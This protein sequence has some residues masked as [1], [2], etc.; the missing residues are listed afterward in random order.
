MSE[1]QC[2]NKGCMKKYIESENHEEACTFHPG[3]PQFHDAYKIWNCCNKKSTDFSTWF[4]FPGCARGRHDNTKKTDDNM[5]RIAPPQEIRPEKPDDVIVWN[6]LNKPEEN[7]DSN[8]PMTTLLLKTTAGAEAALARLAE[9]KQADSENIDLSALSIG[10]PCR[11][12]CCTKTYDGP[13][14]KKSNCVYHPGVAIFHEGMKFWSCCNKKTSNFNAFM[15]QKGCTTGQHEFAMTEKIKE[16]RQ[17]WFNNGG[18]VHV[19]LYCKGTIPNN[20]AF[21]CNGLLLNASV[22]YG[23]GKKES[24]FDFELFGEIDVENSHVLVSERKVE[25]VLKKVAETISWPMLRYEKPPVKEDENEEL[26]N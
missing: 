18:F 19:N 25:M 4:G 17:D 11:N 6:G 21:A 26:S 15:E 23:N 13:D 12:A 3:P 8:R 1:F 16:V 9:Q 22:T 5:M 10:T 7:R 2:Y 20:S 14:A 24:T